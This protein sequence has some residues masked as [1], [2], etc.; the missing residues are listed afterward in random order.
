MCNNLPFLTSQ[1][2]G[3]YK[4]RAEVRGKNPLKLNVAELGILAALRGQ[5]KLWQHIAAK[6]PVLADAEKW[7]RQS[8]VA[9]P[10]A[11]QLLARQALPLSSAE[12]A[13]YPRYCP[14]EALGDLFS[15]SKNL[16]LEGIAAVCIQ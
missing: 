1:A 3:R 11:S 15:Y 9:S 8:V 6:R 5:A 14:A 12:A 10:G 2:S 7:P 4:A 16:Q 13:G